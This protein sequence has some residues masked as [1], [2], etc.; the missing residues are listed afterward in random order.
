MEQIWILKLDNY[1][2]CKLTNLWLCLGQNVLDL[3]FGFCG[4]ISICYQ[5][6]LYCKI[7][8]GL[9]GICGWSWIKSCQP[10]DYLNNNWQTCDV[11]WTLW[12]GEGVNRW[13]CLNLEKRGGG[14]W[15]QSCW[16]WVLTFE[17]WQQMLLTNCNFHSKTWTNNRNKFFSWPAWVKFNHNMACS[18]SSYVG[19]YLVMNLKHSNYIGF[20]VNSWRRCDLKTS[21]QEYKYHH[22][23][24]LLLN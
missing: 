8:G 3:K 5:E 21:C 20:V 18:S 23:I 7:C 11:V 24:W 14:K 9:C 1:Q 16:T 4:W 10:S 6:L 12:N 15:M 13:C 17:A 2:K 19:S 22:F